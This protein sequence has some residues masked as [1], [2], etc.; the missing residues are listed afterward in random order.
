M[1]S[2][3]YLTVESS[4]RD[5][6]R[7]LSEIVEHIPRR[8]IRQLIQAKLVRVLRSVY[9]NCPAQRQRW[10]EAGVKLR[11]IRSSD[12]LEHIPF[13]SGVELAEHPEDYLCVPQE[14]LTHVISTSGTKGKPK[15]IW[16]TGDDINRQARM[17]GTNLRR[18]PSATRVAAIFFV[19]NPTWSTVA[20]VRCGIEEAGI[21][22]LWFG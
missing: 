11:D 3:L 21:R 1:L 19:D 8:Y 7:R 9:R 16:L 20:I 15:K 6:P 10:N 2:W 14:E 18:F 13:T 5:N 4:V 22:Q 17:I 12:I